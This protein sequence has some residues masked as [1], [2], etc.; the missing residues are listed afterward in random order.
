M[1][2]SVVIFGVVPVERRKFLRDSNCCLH[3]L[4][5]AYGWFYANVYSKTNAV[6]FILVLFC[7]WWYLD[8]RCLYFVEFGLGLPLILLKRICFDKLVSAI[9]FLLLPRC[10]RLHQVS[11]RRLNKNS[12]WNQ[13]EQRWNRLFVTAGS[14]WRR[15]HCYPGW[16]LEHPVMGEDAQTSNALIYLVPFVWLGPLPLYRSARLR[17][18]DGCHHRPERSH[19]YRREAQL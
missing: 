16:H 11:C 9:D 18:L 13:L 2:R 14:E 3:T 15:I 12:H 4:W 19:R 10:I 8:R 7:S 1:K 6:G 5:S 17:H